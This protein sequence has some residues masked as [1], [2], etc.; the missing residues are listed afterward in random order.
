MR[1]KLCSLFLSACLLL[2]LVIPARAVET[3]TAAPAEEIIPQEQV[4]KLYIA[5]AEEWIRLRLSFS[6]TTAAI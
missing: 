4:T 2:S 5:T 1:K 6:E 3:E